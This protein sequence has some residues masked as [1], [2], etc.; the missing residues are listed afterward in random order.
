M[1]RDAFVDMAMKDLVRPEEK[2]E[3]KTDDIVEMAIGDLTGQQKQ[4]VEAKAPD[5]PKSKVNLADAFSKSV[6]GRVNEN[7]EKDELKDT[8]ANEMYDAGQDVLQ[9]T[10]KGLR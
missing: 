1:E 3:Q 4:P 6:V 7:K 5:T 8:L 2:V 9:R 10:L